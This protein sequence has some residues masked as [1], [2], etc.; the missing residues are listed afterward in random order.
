MFYRL[1]FGSVD[2]NA[3]EVGVGSALGVFI[4][5]IVGLGAGIGQHFLRKREVEQ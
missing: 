3:N 1:S 2:S 4:F 5:V